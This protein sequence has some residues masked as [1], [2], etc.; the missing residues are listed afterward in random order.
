V[1]RATH[2]YKS[3]RTFV[4]HDELGDGRESVTTMF[5]IVSPDSL[6]YDV[7]G[8]GRAII[9][10]SRRWDMPAGSTTWTEQP[11]SPITQ[12]TPF[13]IHAIDARL[14]GTARVHGRPA[15]KVSFYDPVT[16][17]WFTLLIDKVSLH[18]LDMRMTAHSHFM[19][20][21]YW[22]FDAPLRISPP[23]AGTAAG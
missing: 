4:V 17:A 23:G 22:A 21:T 15:W 12:P 14:L 20:D 13:W 1:A 6:S 18:T 10:G 8:G 7:K 2:V 3:L 11:Q 9:I 5:R 19:H 16:P